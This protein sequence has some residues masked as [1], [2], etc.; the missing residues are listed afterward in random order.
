VGHLLGEGIH[1]HRRT[2]FVARKECLKSRVAG[3]HQPEGVELGLPFRR[4]GLRLENSARVGPKD[5]HRYTQGLRQH[6][7]Y[8]EALNRLNTSFHLGYPA[9]RAPESR[10]KFTLRQASSPPELCDSLR[11]GKVVRGCHLAAP[12]R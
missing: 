1:L 2:L 5:A 10:P 9:L 4:R 8:G 12:L 6:L 3:E 7:E 11:K